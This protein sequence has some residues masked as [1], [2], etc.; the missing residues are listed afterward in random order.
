MASTDDAAAADDD[1]DDDVDGMLSEIE[2]TS[3][4]DNAWSCSV[5][6]K[7]HSSP[8]TKGV[9]ST[10]ASS[11]AANTFRIRSSNYNETA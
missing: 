9:D 2:N 1:D 11:H 3:C 5:S 6:K 8:R 7:A 4:C 10:E